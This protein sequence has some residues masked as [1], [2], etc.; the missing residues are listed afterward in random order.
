MLSTHQ[1][2]LL[3]SKIQDPDEIKEHGQYDPHY[4]LSLK[5]AEN[6]AKNIKDALVKID[7]ANKSKYESNYSSFYSRLEKLFKD[8]KAKFNSVKKKN[9][10][11]GHA[12]FAYFS[13]DFGLVQNSVE[14]TFAE[15][16]PSAK[17]LAELID[18]C[19]KNNVKTIFVE[20]MVSPK[21]SETLAKEVGAKAVQIYTIESKE[22]NKD[23]LQSMKDNLD[24]IYNSLK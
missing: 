5:G 13:R 16:E 1:K 17:K 10:V 14:D 9:I 11:T 21:V 24:K 22:D 2:D 15:G 8:Y 20:D 6:G 19:K 18:Y 4:W 3:Q 23:Y 12:A 7:P